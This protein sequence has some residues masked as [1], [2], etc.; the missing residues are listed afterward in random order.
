M[1]NMLGSGERWSIL[2]LAAVGAIVGI[3]LA[4]I[5]HLLHEHSG[6]TAEQVLW[7]H[8]I[9][10]MLAAMLGGVIV[11]GGGAAIRNWLKRRS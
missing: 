3:T 4:T 9:P 5:L 8:F 7:G 11:F 10:R 1:A 6:P 2:L